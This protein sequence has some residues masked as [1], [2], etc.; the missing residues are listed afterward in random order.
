MSVWPL[1]A[2]C[3]PA[4]GPVPCRYSF[5]LAAASACIG[6]TD[7]TVLDL[8]LR[9]GPYKL[10]LAKVRAAVHGI[11]LG[12]LVPMGKERVVTKDG[13]VDLAPSVLLGDVPGKHQT[14]M[15]HRRHRHILGPLQHTRFGRIHQIVVQRVD[16]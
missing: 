2:H 16:R 14:D 9:T 4:N 8:L 12:A 15:P 3:S 6:V 7:E 5:H 13:L 1:C 10:S 11:D